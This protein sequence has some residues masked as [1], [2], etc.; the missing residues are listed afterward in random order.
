MELSALYSTGYTTSTIPSLIHYMSSGD[1]KG[2]INGQESGQGNYNV[3]LNGSFTYLYYNWFAL[4]HSVYTHAGMADDHYFDIYMRKPR[5]SVGTE[6]RFWTPMIPWL[7]ASIHFTYLK[8]NSNW[9]HL[10]I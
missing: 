9:F 5:V 8:G 10:D 6:F 3:K 1:V 2:I 7:A 4:E